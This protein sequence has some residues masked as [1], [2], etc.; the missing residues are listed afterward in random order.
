MKNNK[1][2]GTIIIV[3]I[4]VLTIATLVIVSINRK[5]TLDKD[6]IITTAK[7]T[8][9]VIDAPKGITTRQNIAKYTYVYKNQ[10]FTKVIE[11]YNKPIQEGACYEIKVANENPNINEI[12]LNKKMDC[13]NE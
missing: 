2:K 9:V 10:T 5:K 13:N 11:I 12:N 7:I 8:E 1:S 6:F 3:A 4:L